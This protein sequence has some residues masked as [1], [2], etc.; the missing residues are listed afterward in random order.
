MPVSVPPLPSL[1]APAHVAAA[2]E[3][4]Q[5]CTALW[6]ATL[7][8]MTAFMHNTAPAHRYLLARRIARNL[9]TLRGQEC[10]SADSRSRFARLALRWDDKAR[11]LDPQEQTRGGTGVVASLW[12]AARDA[13]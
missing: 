10:F 8:L 4:A 13:T 5:A 3:L 2:P 1:S 11:A 7:S 12:R 6:L 9:D